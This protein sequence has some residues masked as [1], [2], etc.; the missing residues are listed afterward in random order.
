MKQFAPL[1]AFAASAWAHGYVDNGTIGGVYYQPERISRPIQGNGPVTDVTL[2]DLQCGGDTADGVVGSEPA[3]L[4]APATAGSTVTLH[5]TLW[6]DSHVGP[7]ITYMGR[8][9][10]TGCQDYLPGTDAIW[11]K[12]AEAGRDGTSDTWG[13]SPLMV[14]GN[15]GVQYTIPSCL[16]AGY[17]LVRHEI[18][19]LHAAY[20]YPGA[21]FYP[22]CHQLNITS[23]GTTTPSD[24]VA[25]P[26]A[27]Q[28]TDPG[29]TYN[30][31]QATTYT[32]PGPDVFTC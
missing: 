22:G 21:Q 9:P 3:P 30:A 25:F 1:L 17:Y 8:C 10:D 19:A 15:A 13:D 16:K 27:Y 32:I 24:L 23:S 18:I 14:S 4:H 11:F 31:Y 20:S 12:V 6:P 7:V 5:W 29:I 26:G 28:G 2:I